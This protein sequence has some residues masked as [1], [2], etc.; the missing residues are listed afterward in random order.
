MIK[1][2]EKDLFA[3]IEYAHKIENILYSKKSKFQDIKV[4]ES[5][6]FG[7]MLILDDIVQ[8]T[9]RDEFF[10]HEMIAHVPM[11]AHPDPKKIVVIGGGDGGT[12]REVLKHDTVEK[13]HFIEIDEDVINVSKKFFP[14][15]SHQIDNPNVEIRCMDGAEF[16]TS[17]PES[18]FDVIIVDS[19]DIVGIAT[20]LFTEEFFKSVKRALSKDGFFVTHS[21]TIHFHRN[22]LLEVQEKMQKV[23]NIV[24]LYTVNI[25]TYTGNWWTFSIGSESL[26]PRETRR[27]FNVK[28]RYYDHEVHV[29]SFLPKSLYKRLLQK[30]LDW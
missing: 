18:S 27:P 8:L 4:L 25:A 13:I 30:E 3:P 19:T 29:N 20:S 28:T 23:F 17:C 10:Y 2:T 6:Y 7:K 9:E 22:L 12:V 5:P 15:I 21:E 14:T 1:F 16:L 26:S 24:D 11:Y